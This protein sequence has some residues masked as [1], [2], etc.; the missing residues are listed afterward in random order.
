MDSIPLTQTD[1]PVTPDTQKTQSLCPDCLALLPA[2][3]VIRGNRVYLEKHCP[4]HGSFSVRIW[5]GEPAFTG[6][7]RPKIPT[8]PAHCG[9]P[10]EKGCPFDCGLCPD[11]R[12]RSCTIILEV[13]DRCNLACPVCFA[14]ARGMQGDDPP[15]TQIQ[16]WFS[17]ARK[18]GPGSN[19][20][21]SG[22]EPTVRDDL[23]RI[24]AMGREAG[25]DFIQVNTNGLRLARD[26]AY[27][28]ELKA[29][30]LASIFLQFD[31]TDDGI[32][33][34]LRGRPLW[35]EKQAA[36]DACEKNRIGV[37]LVPTMV[38]GINDRNI[39]RI[40]DLAVTRSPAVRSV[41]FQPVSYFGRVP[42]P[43]KDAD[44]MTLPQLMRAIEAQTDGRFKAA[45]F[46]PPGC[47]NALCSFNASFLVMPDRSVRAVA[48]SAGGRC[49]PAPIPAEAGAASAIAFVAR[50]WRAPQSCCDSAAADCAPLAPTDALDL[51]AF[52]RR[53]KTHLLSVSAMA[54]Q[55]VWN[56]DLERARDCC[57]HVMAPDTRLIPFC[58]YN[59]TSR[60]GQR[61]YRT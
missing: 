37:V 50:Q 42:H 26:A 40:L 38:P 21:L 11:H 25:F 60:Q 49:C 41:H 19:I 59:L 57:I 8:R 36:I 2:R 7:Q 23:P 39:G 54:F 24:V 22:G 13:T 16:R 33:R 48:G 55:D 18:A 17:A 56:L 5:D 20:Q 28:R 35:A 32:Y 1:A 15:L 34:K 12:Q 10:V 43:P 44:R 45:D 51:D 27:V 14:D 61:L 6:W 31:G 46:N 47:E 3:R 58:L 9:H 52:I 29:A 4:E 30:G 53:A